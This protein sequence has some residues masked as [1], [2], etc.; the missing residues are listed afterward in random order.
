MRGSASV[1]GIREITLTE[2][3]VR[4]ADDLVRRF[5]GE[6][7]SADEIGLLTRLAGHR[8]VLPVRLTDA[9]AG[10]RRRLGSPVTVVRRPPPEEDVGPTPSHW[11]LRGRAATAAH[12]LWLALVAMQAGDPVCWQ[13]LQDGRLFND[14]LPIRGEEH[15]QTGHGSL[16]HLDFHVEDAFDDHRCDVLALLCLRNPDLVAT[17]VADVGALA[18]IGADDD[19]LLRRPRFGILPDPE[20]LRTSRSADPSPVWRPVLSGGSQ[21]YLRVDPA[22]TTTAPGDDASAQAFSRLCRRLEAAL[23]R[24]RLGP[25]DLVVIDNHRAVH[26]RDPFAPRYDGTDRW[27]RK[28]TLTFDLQRSSGRRR[29][30]SRALALS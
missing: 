9:L 4:P 3:E 6:Y 1:P 12:D 23:V 20:H 14:V 15:A 16:H 22:Y 28:L 26:G 18:G 13:T 8:D 21:P 7:G 24:V 2:R 25:G 30:G 5:V 19:E 17:T 10:V 29:D 11:R 27:L